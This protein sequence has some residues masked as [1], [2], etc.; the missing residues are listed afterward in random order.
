MPMPSL[1]R[2]SRTAGVIAVVA[3]AATAC[4][5]ATAP[6]IRVMSLD[7]DVIF[8]KTESTTTIDPAKVIVAAP[9]TGTLP[10][11]PGSDGGA[12][13]FVSGQPDS[14]PPLPT[15][16]G[17]PSV[18]Q[19]VCPDPP[20]GSSGGAAVTFPATGKP[21]PGYYLYKQV[22]GTV[23][24]GKPFLTKS[25][26]VN[27][28]ILPPSKTVTT[29]VPNSLL[30]PQTRFTYQE[31]IP[32]S[33]G[34]AITF[35]FDVVNNPIPSSTQSGYGFTGEFTAGV[36]NGVSIVSEVERDASGKAVWSFNP[37]TPVTLIPLPVPSGATFNSTG[38]DPVTGQSLTISGTVVKTDRIVGCGTFIQGWQVK[39]TEVGRG[40]AANGDV[41]AVAGT[42]TYDVAT[43]YGGIL[44]S[45]LFEGQG[46]GTIA[47][48]MQ[49]TVVP[50]KTA[51]KT[52]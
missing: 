52:S 14:Q 51:T 39:A 41:T 27:V 31:I 19:K 21:L 1:F 24:A 7:D 40:A 29:T 17:S 42:A 47:G 10:M 4:G 8:G 49:M 16:P 44:L 5:G 23:V 2:S 34:N 45:S 3:L 38:T 6:G 33:N 36:D 35:T 28:Q 26:L 15:F 30:P 20:T 48:G 11:L 22:S 9:T 12:P 50:T 46:S 32:Q 18:D 43:Q 25:K 13:P 37:A